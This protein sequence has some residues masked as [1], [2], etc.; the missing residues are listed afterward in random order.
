MAEECWWAI[1]HAVRRSCCGQSSP[2][3]LDFGFKPDSIGKAYIL[4]NICAQFRL[5]PDFRERSYCVRLGMSVHRDNTN[6][7]KTRAIWVFRGVHLLE[8]HGMLFGRQVLMFRI[9]LPPPS[10][11]RKEKSATTDD[12]W[13]ATSQKTWSQPALRSCLVFAFHREEGS[14][15]F[16]RKFD[17]IYQTKFHLN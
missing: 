17:T 16:L 5:A 6:I 8:C 11:V 13:T 3:V 10:S 12:I 9:I 7:N 15:R 1:T 14:R 4:D 2:S